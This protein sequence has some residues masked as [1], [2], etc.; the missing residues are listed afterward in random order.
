M[1]GYRDR[2]NFDPNA[3]WGDTGPP[4][5]PFNWAQWT[6]VGFVLVGVTFDLAYLGGRIGL[7]TRLLDSPSL[8]V[9]LP[10]VGAALINS[11]RQPGQQLSEETKR[12]RMLIIAVAF[13]ICILALGAA[14]YFKGA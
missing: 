4:L 6:G 11:R 2:T 5:R 1:S 10:L 9:S 12:K 13:A 7:F 8:G 3:A 14:I